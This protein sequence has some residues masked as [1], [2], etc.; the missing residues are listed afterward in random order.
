M[1]AETTKSAWT[2]SLRS[3]KFNTMEMRNKVHKL[4]GGNASRVTSEEMRL[5]VEEISYMLRHDVPNLRPTR[6]LECKLDHGDI[7]LVYCLPP[8]L[9]IGAVL[10]MC[11]DRR[12]LEMKRNGGVTSILFNSLVVPKNVHVDFIHATDRT[13]RTKLQYFSYNDF[14]GIFGMMSKKYN[15][16]YGSEGFFKRYRDSRGNWH[17]IPLSYN[18]MD[19]LKALGYSPT[20]WE[21]LKTYDDITAFMLD[22]PMFDYRLFVHDSLNQSDKKSMKRPVVEYVVDALRKSGKESLVSDADYF[23]KICFPGL[24]DS[25]QAKINRIE[26]NL[27]VKSKVYSGSWVM[28]NFPWIKEGPEVGKIL[29]LLFDTFDTALDSTPTEDAIEVV[30]KYLTQEKVTN[31]S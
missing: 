16:K 30:E 14:S 12:I 8:T 15:F 11:L 26:A 17:D 23:L 2:I 3:G 24:N 9:G 19:G 18:L 31:V 25:I 1:F 13:F 20:K 27:T 10:S 4:F 6:S 7:D 21:S 22:S 28:T 5:I 29:R